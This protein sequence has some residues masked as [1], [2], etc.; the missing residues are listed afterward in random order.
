MIRDLWH[1]IQ[2]RFGWQRGMVDAIT[3]DGAVWVGFQCDQCG[4]ISGL[5]KAWP[6]P[7]K[8]IR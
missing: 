3:I 8:E 4:N 7:Q 6:R 5:H 1:R 2:H